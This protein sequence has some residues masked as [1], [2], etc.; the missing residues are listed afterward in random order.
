MLASPIIQSEAVSFSCGLT[1]AREEPML[2][3]GRVG[4]LRR[5]GEILPLVMQRLEEHED[6]ACGA[7]RGS[8]EMVI[9]VR[10]EPYE[11]LHFSAIEVH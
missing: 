11:T 10:L 4:G 7:S 2:Q 3:V 8:N 5:L 9:A 1:T 6:S